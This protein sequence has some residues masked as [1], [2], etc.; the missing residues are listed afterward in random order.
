MRQIYNF[1]LSVVAFLLC[2]NSTFAIDR[3][4]NDLGTL[5]LGKEYTLSGNNYSYA[6][7]TPEEDGYIQVYSSSSNTFRPFKVWK[8]SAKE[9]MALADNSFVLTPLI[10]KDYSGFNYELP[11][12]KEVTY[13]MCASTMAGDNIKVTVKTEPKAIEYYGSSV[14]EGEV[15]SPTKTSSVSFNFNRPVVASSA[16]IIYGDNQREAVTSRASSTSYACAVAVDVKSALVKLAAVGKINVGDELTIEVKGISEDLDYVAEGDAPL[17]YGD[18]KLKVKLGALPA[19][20][21]S[22]TL[23]GVPVTSSTKFLT[24]YG[25]GKGK[26]VLTFSKNLRA[27]GNTAAA[28]LRFGDSDKQEQ[29]GY[30]QENN[31]EKVGDFTLQISGKQIIL[32]FSNKRRTVAD[33]VKSTESNREDAFTKIN[34]EINKVKSSDGS[35][36]YSESSQTMG[37]FNFSFDLDVPVANVTSEFTPAN[38]KSI[39]DVDEVEIWITDAN[40]LSFDGVNFKYVDENNVEQCVTVTDYTWEADEDDLE[41]DAYTL[42]VKIPEEVKDKNNVVV[43]LNNVLCS[44]GKDYSN[45][46]AAKYNVVATGIANISV[47]GNDTVKV[48][49]LNGQ[50]VSE[51]KESSAF[52]GLKG[53][54]IVN[55]KKVVFE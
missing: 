49:N 26:L 17:T 48:Y 34:L 19:M 7:F 9:T 14:T 54:Y 1:L 32:D 43:S 23:D 15:V 5:E 27:T 51:G 4:E 20:L 13:Y 41:E 18:V 21:E 44:D 40:Q 16:A 2:V 36:A 31:D 52:Q 6:E 46:I 12:K 30:Y 11:V 38:G 24:W 33:M 42:T 29:G 39:K 47:E 45:S 22:A 35:L 3:T 10:L 8:G 25:E 50:L 55:G 37:K 28:I 53:I